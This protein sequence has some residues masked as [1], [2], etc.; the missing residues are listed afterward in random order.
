MAQ[1]SDTRKNPAKHH[2]LFLKYRQTNALKVL[3]NSLL[4]GDDCMRSSHCGLVNN[5]SL[6]EFSTG[7]LTYWPISK[8]PKIR[9][10]LP[11]I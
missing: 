5:M 2:F 3:G 6:A 7:C 10:L 9:C 11:G 8:N 4:I 1:T